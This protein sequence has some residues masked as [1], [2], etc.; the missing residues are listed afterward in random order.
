MLV[1]AGMLIGLGIAASVV[2]VTEGILDAVARR[3]RRAVLRVASAAALAVASVAVLG[4]AA[5]LF[6]PPEVWIGDEVQE[7]ARALAENIAQ[8]MNISVLGIPLGLIGAGVVVWRRRSRSAA[9][10]R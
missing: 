6:I 8:L 9:S 4:L 7:K 3:W 10:D 5:R 1:L 2:L